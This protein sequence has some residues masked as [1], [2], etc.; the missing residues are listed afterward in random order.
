[1]VIVLGPTRPGVACHAWAASAAW[2]AARLS[3][4]NTVISSARQISHALLIFSLPYLFCGFSLLAGP[5]LPSPPSSGLNSSF[6]SS[7]LWRQPSRWVRQQQT[8][9]R[10][11][12]VAGTISVHGGVARRGWR[13]RGQQAWAAASIEN[14]RRMT[15][16]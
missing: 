2:Q 11:A 10:Q 13:V 6:S 8:W 12:G 14:G 15:Q 5:P 9:R 16:A 4:H 7:I 3:P 1:M